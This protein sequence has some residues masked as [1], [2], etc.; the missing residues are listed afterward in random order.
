MFVCAGSAMNSRKPGKVA[1]LALPASTTVVVPEV[2]H[3]LSALI[4]HVVTP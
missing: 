2:G 4:P 3:T 1:Q